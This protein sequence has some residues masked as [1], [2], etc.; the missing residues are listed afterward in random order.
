MDVFLKTTGAV[1]ICAVVYLVLSQ[2]SKDISLLLT[3]VACCMI[4]AVCGSF[5]EPVFTFVHELSDLAQMDSE[6]LFILFK[7]VGIAFLSEVTS[8]ICTDIGNAAMG[9]A[10]QVLSTAIILWLSL[11]LFSSLMDL[12]T[13]M[14]EKL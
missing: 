9:K 13:Q 14:V 4:L 7:T 6:V 2:R 10:L 5:L 12:L 11:P 8:M 3:V 1:L